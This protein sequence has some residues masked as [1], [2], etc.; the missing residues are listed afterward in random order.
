M[1]DGRGDKTF[2]SILRQIEDGRAL[3]KLLMIGD[4]IYADDLKVIAQDE[5]VD[6]YLSRYRDVFTQ[7]HIRKLMSNVSTYMTLDDHEIENNWPSDAN[8]KDMMVKYPA[9]IHAYQIYQVSHSPI[10]PTNDDGKLVG[11]PD[12]YYYRFRD[13]CCDFFV[14]D[15]RTERDHKEDEI[16]SDRQMNELLEWLDDGLDLGACPRTV[17]KKWPIQFLA[18]QLG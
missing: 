7:K 12:K 1:F 6:Q 17:D 5:K 11:V 3:D 18:S 13:G 9:A 4:Q 2:R 8:S 15:T 10:L 14:T 16:I